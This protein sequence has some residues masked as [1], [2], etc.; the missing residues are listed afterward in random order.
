MSAGD[1]TYVLNSLGAAQTVEELYVF[2]GLQSRKMEE[3]YVRNPL[4]PGGYD[5]VY[6]N[7]TVAVPDV[8][9]VSV[10]EP[11]V[12]E[13]AVTVVATTPAGTLTYKFQVLFDA[14][15]DNWLT[16]QDGINNEWTPADGSAGFFWR[17]VVTAD[18]GS[19]SDSETF[20]SSGRIEEST[21]TNN[22]DTYQL[23]MGMINNF[24]TS[25][26][27][28][29]FDLAYPDI[30]G[31]NAF[32][33]NGSNA[34]NGITWPY[35]YGPRS[36]YSAPNDKANMPPYAAIYVSA[37]EAASGATAANAEGWYVFGPGV[38]DNPGNAGYIDYAP[39]PLA[40]PSACNSAD[41][42]IGVN[43][44]YSAHTVWLSDYTGTTGVGGTDSWTEPPVT[45]WPLSTYQGAGTDIAIHWRSN[46]GNGNF[47]NQVNV[48]GMDKMYVYDNSGLTKRGIQIGFG[49][50]VARDMWLNNYTGTWQVSIEVTEAGHPNFGTTYTYQWPMPATG[51]SYVWDATTAMLKWQ[52]R[53]DSTPV[54]ADGND[55]L[56]GNNPRV[57][58]ELL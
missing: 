30:T 5:I 58:Q 57:I 42:L 11:A 32:E 50:T 12:E 40:W 33:F 46:N 18:D 7:A 36:R 4:S 45:A 15:T 48:P 31:A 26:N 35:L 34:G 43:T 16:F 56:Y 25:S 52:W 8:T 1:E 41:G 51:S 53:L 9:I 37:A 19:T 13:Q 14:A 22:W 6:Y 54:P 21:A 10:T 55:N 3:L 39:N 47:I 29:A 20:L 17:V 2:D 27:K 24:S 49:N 38:D 28:I 23:G 44:G